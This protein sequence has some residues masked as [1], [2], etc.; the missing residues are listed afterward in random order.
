MFCQAAIIRAAQQAA[1]HL[2]Q[3]QHFLLGD[4]PVT[5]LLPGPFVWLMPGR[6]SSGISN[7]AGALAGSSGDPMT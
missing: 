3:V 6:L 5:V 7:S 4:E 2:D 1:K